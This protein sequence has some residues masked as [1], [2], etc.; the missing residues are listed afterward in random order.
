MIYPIEITTESVVF[1]NYSY[2]RKFINDF[3][4]QIDCKCDVMYYL[5]NNTCGSTGDV[6]FNYIMV[7]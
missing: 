5:E 7:F 6:H 2:D 4:Y 3:K 1:Y